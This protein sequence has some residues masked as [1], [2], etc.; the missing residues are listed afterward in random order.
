MPFFAPEYSALRQPSV[1]RVPART[2]APAPDLEAGT[3]H[4]RPRGEVSEVSK[5]VVLRSLYV[6]Y[7]IVMAAIPHTHI[8]DAIATPHA[9]CC[10]AASYESH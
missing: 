6:F 5:G 2:R 3:D 8:E 1:R 4:A 9:C 7:K 10:Q